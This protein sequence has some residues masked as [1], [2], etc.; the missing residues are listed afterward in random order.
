MY[1]QFNV[2]LHFL[3]KTNIFL[4]RHALILLITSTFVLY[5]W[6]LPDNATIRI[7]VFLSIKATYLKFI[8]KIRL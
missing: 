5:A 7:F 4:I 2:I 6:E 8:L 1:R 3:K